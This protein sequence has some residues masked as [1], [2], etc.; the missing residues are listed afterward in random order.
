VELSDA[1]T[2]VAHLLGA[3]VYDQDGRR[4]G[5]VRELR[6]HH[7]DDGSVVVDELLLGAKALLKRTRGPG[8]EAR[9]IPLEAVIEVSAERI[10]V[11]RQGR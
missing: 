11:R 10:V 1:P 2:G 5:R 4:L 6:G 8:P 3:R 9:G 7:E